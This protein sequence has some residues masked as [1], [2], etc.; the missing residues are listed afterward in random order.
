MLI[1]WNYKSHLI[2]I[3]IKNSQII[4]HTMYILKVM[5]PAII[6]I[7]SVLKVD[8]IIYKR[9]LHDPLGITEPLTNYR[10]SFQCSTTNINYTRVTMSHK[11]IINEGSFKS[12]KIKEKDYDQTN[13]H[14]ASTYT[15]TVFRKDEEEN[16]FRILFFVLASKS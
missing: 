3:K 8:N 15:E 5:I 16:Q 4:N 11:D 6:T 9:N 1:M 10:M 13:N 2:P 12:L 14:I 7:A